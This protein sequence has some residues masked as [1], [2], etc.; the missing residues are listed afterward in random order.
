MILEKIRLAITPHNLRAG[1]F[2][3]LHNRSASKPCV[4]RPLTHGNLPSKGNILAVGVVV[5]IWADEG[6]ETPPED[7]ASY[8]AIASSYLSKPCRAWVAWYVDEEERQPIQVTLPAS[9][10][11]GTVPRTP[12]VFDPCPTDPRTL[13]WSPD[14]PPDVPLRLLLSWKPYLGQPKP[15]DYSTHIAEG[16]SEVTGYKATTSRKLYETSWLPA[17]V[18]KLMTRL[19][20]SAPIRTGRSIKIFRVALPAGVLNDLNATVGVRKLLPDHTQLHP[21]PVLSIDGD[22]LSPKDTTPQAAD[23]QCCSILAILPELRGALARKT[24]YDGKWA[25][26]AEGNGHIMYLL[27]SGDDTEE[28]QNV[29]IPRPLYELLDRGRIL[30]FARNPATGETL[31]TDQALDGFRVGFFLREVACSEVDLLET[32]AWNV[33]TIS[34]NNSDR[35]LIRVAVGWVQEDIAVQRVQP[36]PDWHELAGI[37]PKATPRTP[38]NRQHFADLVRQLEQTVSESMVHEEGAAIT[39]ALAERADLPQAGARVLGADSAQ[40]AGEALANSVRED[41]EKRDMAQLGDKDATKVT[42]QQD[43][44][45]LRL[46]VE[47][48][49]EVDQGFSMGETVTGTVQEWVLLAKEIRRQYEVLPDERRVAL[50]AYLTEQGLDDVLRPPKDAGKDSLPEDHDYFVPDRKKLTSD[51]RR[52]KRILRPLR[53]EAE[54]AFHRAGAE[55]LRRTFV[56]GVGALTRSKRVQQALAIPEVSGVVS[57]LLGATLTSLLDEQDP[58]ESWDLVGHLAQELRVEGVVHINRS[59]LSRLRGVLTALRETAAMM[60]PAASAPP[61]QLPPPAPAPTASTE[62][63]PHANAVP[64]AH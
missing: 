59:I 42:Q 11:E 33:H 30:L 6:D 54:K 27:V 19:Y 20:L 57:Y 4:L 2:V 31:F 60:Q 22:A 64:S 16:W 53:E 23:K 29:Q 49:R 39:Q 18:A 26:N 58:D 14:P 37:S 38:E 7:C 51:A 21:Y 55:Q 48:T 12:L 32:P 10:E 17:R 63:T 24:V 25:G 15:G 47:R 1:S 44:K 13:A 5:R 28:Y 36:P 43:I 40:R 56:E 46:A 35:V 62:P 9:V 52:T 34:H 61:P 45:D 50:L 8:E 41:K 3:F